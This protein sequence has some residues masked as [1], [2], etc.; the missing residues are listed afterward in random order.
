MGYDFNCTTEVKKARRQKRCVWCGE[1]CEPHRIKQVA[2]F[3]GDFGV[4]F[5][6]PECHESSKKADYGGEGFEPHSYKR[7]SIEYKY[8]H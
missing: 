2:V 4:D 5:W 6:H 7:G 1:F 8:D 3:E